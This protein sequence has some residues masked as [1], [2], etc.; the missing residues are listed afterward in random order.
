MVDTI[1]VQDWLKRLPGGSL[2]EQ[3]TEEWRAFEK[4][5]RPVVTL[6]GTY[7]TGK[8]SLLRRLL[9]DSG[10]EAPEWLT[11]SARHETFEV[12]DVEIGG[13]LVRDTPGFMV[14][15]SDPRAQ[16]NSGRAMTAVGLTDVAIAVLTPQLV[17][18]ERDVLQELV[19]RRWPGGALWFV[20]SRFDE[21][22]VDPEYDLD[23][24][25]ELSARKVRE[26]R[27]LLELDDR[28]EIFVVSQDPFQ[29][30][31]AATLLGR[32]TWDEFR[33]WDGMSELSKALETVDSS[34]L[35]E[36]RDAA[37]QRYWTTILDKAISELRQ[38][39]SDC[40]DRAAVAATGVARR[41]AWESELDALDRAAQADLDGLVEELLHQP[42]GTAGLDAQDLQLEIQRA[43]DEWFVKHHARL[44]QLGRS[45]R[46]A[47]ERECA[48]P[49][50]GDFTSLVEVVRSGKETPPTP[51]GSDG[52]A[53][54]VETVGAMLIGLLKAANKTPGLPAGGKSTPRN[55][56]GNL[57]KHIGVVEAALPLAVY[58][59]NIVDTKMADHARLTYDKTVAEKRQVAVSECTRHANETWR[60]YVG[61]VREMIT[62]ETSAQVELDAS[63]RQLVEQLQGA[64][65]A[66]ESL[67][68]EASVSAHEGDTPIGLC[69]GP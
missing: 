7:D 32:D 42:R 58:L 21:A 30:A 33:G 40:T 22:G 68:K 36:W 57:G 11:I 39:L 6:F 25:Q 23:E 26:L 4:I 49:S 8:S 35:P 34:A 31:G 59:T 29:T 47:R 60:P 62:A 17:T 16:N 52:A 41:D 69:P 55:G 43:L 1:A 15:A 9:V 46:K 5:D 24:Y 27:D 50:W 45:I 67:V 63:L 65:I 51:N 13:C 18:A 14:G 28:A 10:G 66:G 64:V 53:K 19:A 44:Q 37:A 38:Q 20:I 48:R 3:Y 56:L 12:N 54:H 2:A 61:E